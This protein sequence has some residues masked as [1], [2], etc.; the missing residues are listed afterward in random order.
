[1]TED[2]QHE[3]AGGEQRIA[4]I[5]GLKEELKARHGVDVDTE[6]GQIGDEIEARKLDW[7]VDNLDS[8]LE[9]LERQNRSQ[10]SFREAWALKKQF[11][12][13]LESVRRGK[14]VEQIATNKQ[15]NQQARASVDEREQREER[16]LFAE[17]ARLIGRDVERLR[18]QTDQAER[19]QTRRAQRSR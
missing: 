9:D 13:E 4:R 8:R 3:Q 11:A 18:G 7:H 14:P 6:K 17:T 10:R 16:A 15:L 1:M 19:S 12:D 5:A 2:K